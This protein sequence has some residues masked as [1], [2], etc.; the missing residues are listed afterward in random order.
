MLERMKIIKITIDV[1]RQVFCKTI[2]E[3][4]SI[5]TWCKETEALIVVL[6][7]DF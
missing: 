2:Q 3:E 1:E 4:N 5:G 7:L 6:I